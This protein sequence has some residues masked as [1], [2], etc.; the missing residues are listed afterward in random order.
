M[1]RCTKGR[2]QINWIIIKLFF[3]FGASPLASKDANVGCLWC[4]L[5]LDYLQALNFTMNEW[6]SNDDEQAYK[7]L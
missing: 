5:D 1:Q 3:S 2:A 4:P 7:N 6:E